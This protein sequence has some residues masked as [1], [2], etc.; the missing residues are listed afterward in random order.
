MPNAADKTQNQTVKALLA[1]REIV[2]SGE[3]VPGERV[4]ELAMVER[5]GVSRTPL[6]TALV[7]LESEGLLKALPS[8]GYAARQFSVRDVFAAIEIRGAIEGLA[9]RFAAERGLSESAWAPINQ[10]QEEIDD[11]IARDQE[12]AQTFSEY[13]PL[14]EQFHAH[15]A[16]LSGSLVVERQIEKANAHPFASASGFINVQTQ[17][18]DARRILLI[19][20]DQH[21]CVLE[22][23]R[24]GEGGRAEALMREHA[25]LAHRYL[26]QV[27]EDRHVMAQMPGASMLRLVS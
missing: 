4:P 25:R 2:L 12:D 6:R 8:G 1:L 14:N 18:A 22:A 26:R 21:Q 24:A 9:A 15:L 5:I 11:L 27:L 10:V 16:R 17:M 20:Q 7:R 13:V 19:A 23:M 3:L